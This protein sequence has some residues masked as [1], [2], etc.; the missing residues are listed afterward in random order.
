MLREFNPRDIPAVKRITEEALRENYPTSLYL[1]IYNWW[2]EGFEVFEDQGRVVGFV[3][4]VLPAPD[5]ARI[6]MLAVDRDH[7]SRGYG[8]LLLKEFVRR[9]SLKGVRAVELE[10]RKSN[11]A[12]I[13]FYQ[14]LG[15]EVLH[16]LPRFYTDGEDGYKMWREL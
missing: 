3:A 9:S 15:F 6:L 8:T 7:R 16:I 12:A 13:R 14:R 11:L 4:G 5:R 10:V 2:P 1:D